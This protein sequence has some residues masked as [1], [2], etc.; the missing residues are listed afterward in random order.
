MVWGRSG[1]FDGAGMW[2]GAGV[3][4]GWGRSGCGFGQEWFDAIDASESLP[5][6]V[7]TNAV[8]L[9]DG[10]GVNIA[11]GIQVQNLPPSR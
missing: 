2:V 5:T 1:W 10:L 9:R 8:Q 11:Q 7:S 4:V 6:K 3:D